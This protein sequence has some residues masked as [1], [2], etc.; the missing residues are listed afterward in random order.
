QAGAELPFNTELS[1]LPAILVMGQGSSTSTT[2][3]ANIRYSNNDW[4]EIAVRAGL[5]PHISSTFDSRFYFESIAVA[6]ILELNRWN[7]G[8]SYD[9]TTS[10]LT[11]ANNSR[12]AFEVSLIYVHPARSRVRVKCPNF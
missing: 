2:F 4:N 3:G 5:W 6:A 8:F 1:I 12:G 7:V 10:D 9:I 11:R